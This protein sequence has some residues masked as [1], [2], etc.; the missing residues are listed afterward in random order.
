MKKKFF[1]LLTLLISTLLIL[2]IVSLADDDDDKD[3]IKGVITSISGD[4]ISF[5]TKYGEEK[6]VQLNRN[7]KVEKKVNGDIVP[8]MRIEVE[9]K[10]GKMKE[11]E[12]KHSKNERGYNST[13]VQDDSWL[14]WKRTNE[15]NPTA[16]LPFSEPTTISV[17]VN[18]E[19]AKTLSVFPINGQAFVAAS[20]MT[21]LL[22]ANITF[23]GKIGIVE[24]SKLNK[25][26]LFRLQTNVVY[27]NMSKTPI[28]VAPFIYENKLYLPINVLAN[29]LGYH[30]AWDEQT[31]TISLKG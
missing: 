18:N 26:L 27:E 21:P 16:T 20:D 24:V 17:K 11:V 25:E 28:E 31:K 14:T 7:I 9:Y 5:V 15:K 30:L 23:Y 6:N 12:I 13:P 19:Q 22:D 29:G 1:L 4:T 2:P 8:G 10:N 3:E